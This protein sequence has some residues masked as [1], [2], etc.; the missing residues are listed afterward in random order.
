MNT[1]HNMLALKQQTLFVIF[2]CFFP[3]FFTAPVWISIVF[4]T[5]MGYRFIT[6][7]LS[8]EPMPRWILFCIVTACLF[9]LFGKIHSQEIFIDFFLTVVILKCLEIHTVRELKVIIISN[10]YLIL[11]ALIVTQ[12][13]WIILYLFVA[14]FAN[15]SLMLKLNAPEVSLKQI[16]GRSSRQLLIAI[17]LSILLFFI[18]PRFD[19]LWHVPFPSQ[20]SSGFTDTMSPG[21]ITKL[22]N[23][24]STAMQ[25][26]FKNSPILDGYW[27]GLILSNYTGNSWKVS[28]Y[29]DAKFL[30]LP[31][32]SEIEASDYD[33]LLEPNQ[34][35]W[36]FY[37]GYPIAGRSSLIFSPSYGLMRQNQQNIDERFFYSLKIKPAAPYHDLNALEYAIATQLPAN[38]NPRLNAWAK[39]QFAATRQNL[40]AFIIFLHNYIHHQPFWYTHTPPPL[41]AN[42]NQMDSFWFDTKKGFCEHYASAVAYILR[43]AGVPSHVVIG[44]YG[45]QWNPISHAITLHQSDA[46]AWVEYWQQGVGWRQLDPTSFVALERVD[47]AILNRQVDLIDEQDYLTISG[48]PWNRKISLFIDSAQ[49]FAERWFLFYNTNT[50]QNLLLRLGLGPW[51]IGQLLQATV[52]SMIIFFIFLGVFY[53]WRQ[54]RTIDRLLIEYHLLQ[55]E[56]RKFNVPTHP[57]ATLQLQC[58]SLIVKAPALTQILSS[59]IDR[60]EQLRLKKSR[61]NSK[62]ETIALF[63]GLRSVLRRHKPANS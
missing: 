62:K 59:F 24:G 30:S 16:G 19:P 17:P 10:F 2:I 45:G 1:Q 55:Q 25:I 38:S 42:N 29:Q 48:L 18:F 58:D 51:N 41:P 6:D 49:Y 12:E 4:L 33:I 57:S 39:M 31:E 8:Y 36:L 52:A 43:A 35:K 9:L 15:L 37:E 53:Y 34:Q 26:T 63:K 5:I 54:N 7:Y 22:F 11:S 14:I 50:Q 44:Y 21:S 28:S 60:Y 32:L 46:H 61:D 40:P 13:L 47:L 23:D 27:Q 20:A 56:F 3:H